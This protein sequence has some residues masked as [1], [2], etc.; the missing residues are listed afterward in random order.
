VAIAYLVRHRRLR[1]SLASGRPRW[2]IHPVPAD[3]TAVR[4]AAGDRVT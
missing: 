4:V 2:S 1:L 3:V